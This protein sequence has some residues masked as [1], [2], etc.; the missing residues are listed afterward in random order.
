MRTKLLNPIGVR[1]D[2]GLKTAAEKVAEQ[3]RLSLA[4]LIRV[5]LREQILLWEKTGTVA[6]RR[7]DA[8]GGR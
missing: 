1:L 6:F 5:A 3:Y 8:G 4:D 2:E 7:V